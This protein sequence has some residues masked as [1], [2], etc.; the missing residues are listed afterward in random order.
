[1]QETLLKLKPELL[2]KHFFEISKIP[3]GS[4]DEK[5]IGDYIIKVAKE[6][7]L[8]YK[9]DSVGNVVVFKQGT[10][11]ME[12]AK[13]VVIQSHLDMV[14][15]KNKD[16]EHDFTKDPLKLELKGNLLKAK[17]TTLGADNG[18]GVAT[19]LALMEDKTIKHGP[20][21]LLFTI[22]EERG[23]TGAQNIPKD[24]ITGKVMLNLDSEQLGVYC[25]GCAGGQD[26]V[27]STKLSFTKTNIENPVLIYLDVKGLSGG[28][29][30]LDIDKGRA[31]AIKL[32]GRILFKLN[33]SMK[34][35][36]ASV[37]G[38]SRRNVIPREASAHVVVSKKDVD[39][40][41]ET[42][43]NTENDMKFEYKNTDSQLKVICTILKDEPSK[44]IVNDQKNKVIN[45][46][47]SFIH[48]PLEMSKDIPGLV[49]TSTNLAVVRMNQDS[50]EIETS[51]RSFI[52]SAKIAAA[53]SVK[54][55]FN[56]AQFQTNMGSGYPGWTPNAKSR[57]VDICK[58]LNR[59]HLK[60]DY[61]IEA[62]HAGLE[63]GIIG[64]KFPG[65]DMI[66]I[67]ATF[68]NVHSPDEELEVDSVE[69]FWNL[70]IDLIIESGK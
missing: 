22:D 7:N 16:I 28:H 13:P 26:T 50:M 8:K 19:E 27:G 55:A 60:A 36:L 44:V 12:N 54:A 11:G 23:L 45:L 21:E 39:A 49:E 53:E 32:L 56:L 35:D 64:E 40:L 43:K 59:K 24:F 2:W 61:I 66:S 41:A 14:C 4:G 34:L 62:V 63:C 18:V 57:L 25:I 31:N 29:S 65:M 52:E 15:E 58:E 20:I 38:G 46:L 47:N 67:G 5:A 30:G 37:E 6:N 3:H 1:M 68:R 69:P 70:L 51:Q 48:G 17:G 42:V 10:P 9:Q 33:N